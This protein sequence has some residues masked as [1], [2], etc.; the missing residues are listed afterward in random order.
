MAIKRSR[1]HSGALI[2]YD[3]AHHSLPAGCPKVLSRF[4]SDRSGQVAYAFNSLGL[5]RRDA[6]WAIKAGDHVGRNVARALTGRPGRPFRYL[7]LG[8]AASFGVGR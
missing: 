3:G 7:G 6:L 1:R 2:P 5:N 4:T 8:Q